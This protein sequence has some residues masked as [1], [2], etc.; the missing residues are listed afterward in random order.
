MNLDDDND[1]SVAAIECRFTA[2]VAVLR[3]KC[4][5]T[6]MC[7]WNLIDACVPVGGAGGAVGDKTAI[8]PETV[9]V[10][11]GDA[12]HRCV[13]GVVKGEPESAFMGAQNQREIILEPLCGWRTLPIPLPRGLLG[14]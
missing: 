5:F 14:V 11:G 10:R 3:P 4:R 8:Y 2:Q 6:A 13:M 12:D 7:D 1:P 9:G